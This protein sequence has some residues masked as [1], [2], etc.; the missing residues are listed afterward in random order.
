MVLWFF[1]W[2]FAWVCLRSF[3]ETHFC[4]F[5]YH[6]IECCIE[7]YHLHRD[8]VQ[9]SKLI[10]C[11]FNLVWLNHPSFTCEI[12][13]QKRL[14]SKKPIHSKKKP[15][16]TKKTDKTIKQQYSTN[17]KPSQ[18]FFFFFFTKFLCFHTKLNNKT[19]VPQTH[20]NNNFNHKKYKI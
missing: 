6:S 19:H 17:I 7:W 3:Q 9:R 20:K 14:C 11:K 15:N 10:E 16:D 18:K 2:S 12:F 1:F 8:D 13:F 4:W 5:I